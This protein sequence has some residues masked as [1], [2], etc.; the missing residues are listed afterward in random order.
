MTTST[1]LPSAPQCQAQL[2]D[3]L[4]NPSNIVA[5]REQL[6]EVTEPITMDLAE[7][8]IL[9]P[10]ISNLYATKK[11][12]EY[13]IEVREALKT[14]V[15]VLIIVSQRRAIYRQQMSFAA[16]KTINL[17]ARK[18]LRSAIRRQSL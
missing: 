7:Y 9:L 6:F 10:Y 12:D 14:L 5:R 8:E 16:T 1:P 4:Q 2:A 17:R 13:D 3:F 15:S 11:R 18:R